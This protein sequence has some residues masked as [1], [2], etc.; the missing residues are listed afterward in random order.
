[1][2]VKRKNGVQ[3]LRFVAR[4][5]ALKLNLRPGRTITRRIDMTAAQRRSGERRG[6]SVR[7][8]GAAP[9]KLRS[10]IGR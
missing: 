8:S 9:V 3:K 4:P 2:L 7:F 10:R 5:G 1:M 6:F